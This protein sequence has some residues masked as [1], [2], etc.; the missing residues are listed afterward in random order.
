MNFFPV[1]DATTVEGQFQ[2]FMAGFIYS[3]IVASVALMIRIFKAAGK[4]NPDL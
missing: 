2:W 4:A 3:S 1:L